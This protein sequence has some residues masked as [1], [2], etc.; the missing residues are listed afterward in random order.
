MP[1]TQLTAAQRNYLRRLAH[2][3]KPLVQIGKHGLTEQALSTV[4]RTLEAHELIK[5]KF[6]GGHEQKQELAHQI[7]D[8]LNA[9]L[10]SVIGNIVTVYREQPDPDKRKVTL[11]APSTD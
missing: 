6:L 7:A 1:A 2:D 11:P 9:A 10:I 8:Q 4:D 3:L 5:I